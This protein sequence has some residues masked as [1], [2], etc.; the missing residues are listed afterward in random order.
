MPGGLTCPLVT[1]DRGHCYLINAINLF[2]NLATENEMQKVNLKMK[3]D[4]SDHLLLT[5]V[6]NFES[7]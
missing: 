3:G 4:L 1:P 5:W 7:F 2:S 6:V